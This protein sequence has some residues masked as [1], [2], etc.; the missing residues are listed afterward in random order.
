MM[1]N[2]RNS[3]VTHAVDRGKLK[4]DDRVVDLY[5]GFQLKDHPE[6]LGIDEAV[7]GDDADRKAGRV[8]GLHRARIYAS[9]SGT[10]A[11]M[12]AAIGPADLDASSARVTF[13]RSTQITAAIS[14]RA[15]PARVA[16]FLRL[17]AIII[18]SSQPAGDD[19]VSITQGQFLPSTGRSTRG[20]IPTP[21]R[22]RR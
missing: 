7:A 8:V 17:N 22:H 9:R 3:R 20:G 12:R 4:W 5:P 21:A 11:V 2:A 13:G 18:G 16:A 10:N 1:S 14:I 15:E 6:A 19:D